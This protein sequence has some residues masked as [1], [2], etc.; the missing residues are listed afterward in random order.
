MTETRFHRHFLLF[1][2]IFA[3]A[4]LLLPTL[5][6]AQ[7]GGD[8]SPTQAAPQPE[9]MAQAASAARTAQYQPEINITCPADV[10][11]GQAFVLKVNSP[12]L[13]RIDLSWTGK[14]LSITATPAAGGGMEAIALLPVDLNSKPGLKPLD[15]TIVDNGRKIQ[16]NLT[17]R[18]SEKRYPRQELKVEPKF[19]QLSKPDLERSRA[20][21]KRVKA[22]LAKCSPE[23]YWQLPFVRP[24][25]G[26]VS[27]L[28]GVAR[29]FNGEPR[30]AHKGLDL[31]GATGTPIVAC[32]AG[33]VVLADNLFFSGNVVYLDH[34]LGVFTMYCHMSEIKV[35]EGDFVNAGDLL[36][37]VG[38][39]GRVT[40]PHLHLS[41]TV[42]GTSVD[43]QVLLDLNPN[44]I[45][46]YAAGNINV[47]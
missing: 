30:S 13:E 41:A 10:L 11:N 32:A 18:V 3:Y 34:G 5:G 4:C 31:R 45:P 24:V 19:V 23:R 39:T 35:K 20:E 44:D 14:Q 36:G 9:S 42:L 43:P 46:P 2:M 33:R 12:H 8:V 7:S 26:S 47:N 40:G 6:C 29:V 17:I 22:V 16:E 15:L 1:I 28:F 38:A 37:L 25:P 21:S 27:S